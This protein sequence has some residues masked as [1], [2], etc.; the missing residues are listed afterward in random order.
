MSDY[1]RLRKKEP[2]Y[3]CPD[4]DDA[5]SHIEEARSVNDKLRELLREALDALEAAETHIAS[6]E[7]MTESQQDTIE[8]LRAELASKETP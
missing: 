4:F 1:A 2:G 7:R 3:S 8:A 6:L 5:I